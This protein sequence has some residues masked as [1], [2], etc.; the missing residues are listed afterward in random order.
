MFGSTHRSKSLV[1]VADI[2]SASA[3]VAVI[4]LHES[5]PAEIIASHRVYL[6]Y[7]ER[8]DDSTAA[9]VLAGLREAGKKILET[10]AQTPQKNSSVGHA[11]AIMYAPWTRSKTVNA[12]TVFAKEE[13]ITAAMIQEQAQLAI[14]TDKEFDR[15]NVVESTVVRVELNGYRTSA[16]LGKSAHRLS[17][18]ALLS[19]G[20]AE[21]RKG[22]STELAAL[23]PHATIL[24][25]SGARTLISAA[26]SLPQLGS[27]YV[28]MA[29]MGETT[30]VVVVR[31]GLAVQHALIPE[32]IRTI[33]K[34]LSDKGMQEET[35]SLLRMIERDECNSDACE[36]I[37]AAMARAEIDLA[38]VYGE[39]LTKLAAPVRLPPDLVLVTQDDLRPWLTKFFSRIDFTQCTFTTQ[40][41]TVHGL[42]RDDLK[43]SVVVEQSA[44]S[45]IGLMIAG[46]LVNSEQGRK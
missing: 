24:E 29:V 6:P 28:I 21:V 42:S 31:D 41:F 11:Y 3:A 27:D 30:S 2:G 20:V 14:A 37:M 33:V 44:S 5:A 45:D 38:R 19:E 9:A 8:N 10:M 12:T 39:N 25:R 17:V 1:A 26:E 22:V 35:L 32:G 40:P 7:A 18:S 16:P 43:S 46:A 23:F 34:R 15:E 4:A 13:R 36:A